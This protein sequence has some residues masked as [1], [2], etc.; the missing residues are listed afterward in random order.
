M[1]LSF[2]AL[3]VATSIAPTYLHAASTGGKCL[4]VGATQKTKGII[5]V[6]AKYGKSL[7]WAKQKG[8][9]GSAP[10]V[11]T[12]N[13]TTTTTPI[14]VYRAP[15]QS[16]DSAEGCKLK[17]QSYERRVYGNLQAG[18]PPMEK[19]FAKSGV[20]KVALIPI[21]FADLPGEPDPLD[22]VKEQ[23]QLFTDFWDMVTE[24]KVRFEWSTYNG[25]VR[26][27]GQVNRFYQ[28]R[29]GAV[30]YSIA[31]ESLAA[32]DPI[33][34][35]SGIRAV[36][37]ILPKTQTTIGES[38]QGFLHSPFGSSGGYKTSEGTIYNFALAGQ[39]FDQQYKTIWSYWVHETGHMFPLPDLYLQSEQYGAGDFPIPGGPFSG[40]DIMANQDGPSRTLSSWLR[41]IQGWMSDSQ[42][43]CKSFDGLIPTQVMLNP[44]DNR[45]S[46]LKAVM[47]HTSPTRLVVV[48]SRRPNKFD[49]LPSNRS[50]VIVYTVDTTLGHGEGLQRL[51][52]P[53]SRGL[54]NYDNCTAP[55]QLDAIML[56][57]DSVVSD[58][59]KIKVVK[60][61]TYDTVEISR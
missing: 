6:C 41:F 25:W 13:Q 12:I 40:F 58:G 37:F 1:S 33:F 32:A 17:D 29:S 48:E 50:G 14:E 49:C 27:P 56:A 7:K 15:T 38:V 11:D 28:A 45:T 43:Y 54:K 20:F 26:V 30:Q 39:Y 59:V 9:T 51:V 21:D 19:N 8:T 35:F 52:A 61:G 53:V 18:F 5:Y 31:T 46:G 4:K 57:G 23:M 22:R 36:F 44:I 55:P 34:D 16:A 24:G 60:I 3:V 42:V 10:V 2:F 47:I